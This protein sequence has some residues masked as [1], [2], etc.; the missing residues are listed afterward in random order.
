MNIEPTKAEVL[1]ITRAHAKKSTYPDP[2]TET[3][4]VQEARDE[5]TKEMA[6]QGQNNHKAASPSWMRGEERILWQIL[7][8]EVPMKIQNLL[9]TVPQLKK[10][11]LNSIPTQVKRREVVSPTID[12]V[13]REVV[14]PTV[15]PMLLVVNRGCQLTV[16]EMGILGT[17]LTNTIMDRGLGLNVLPKATWKNW[18]SLCC[19][20]PHSTY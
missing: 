6:A 11:I 13:L 1:A 16:V 12:L 2:R 5:I 14:S 8:L 4:R 9:E 20:L 15:D 18:E 17:T 7:Q 10:A 3:E 19:G